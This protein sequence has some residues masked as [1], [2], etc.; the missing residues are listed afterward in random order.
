MVFKLL[1]FSTVVFLWLLLSPLV[2]AQTPSF[3]MPHDGRI[4]SK[5]SR[6]HPGLDLA[7]KLGTLIRPIAEGIVTQAERSSKGLGLMVEVEH[8]GGYKSIYGHMGQIDVTLGQAV[9]PSSI[10]GTVGLTGNTSGPHTH[11]ETYKDGRTVDPLTLLP[12]GN[13]SHLARSSE[14][15]TGG[16][17][18]NIAQLPRT[19]LWE[20]TWLAALLLPLGWWMI[21]KDRI[22]KTTFTPNYI[23][24][25]RRLEQIT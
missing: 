14:N 24:L 1:S 19:G 20:G 12:T 9:T 13:S 4:T 11:L 8:P 18:I 2:Q 3:Q 5:F 23:W 15:A 10:L 16:P 17:A 25:K 7:I 6:S 22:T 21:K